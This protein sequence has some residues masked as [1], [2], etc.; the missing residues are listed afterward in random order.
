MFFLVECGAFYRIELPYMVAQAVKN[1]PAMQET[2][3]M[4]IQSLGWE[5]PLERKW[6]PTPVFLPGESHG[7]RSLV[8]NSSWGCTESDTTKRLNSN[9]N[10][11]TLSSHLISSHQCSFPAALFHSG[12]QAALVI[13]SPWPPLDVTCLQAS[14]AFF[15]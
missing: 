8:D 5:D 4:Q 6:Q 9:N 7:Q 1:L 12:H 15:L 3:E 13:K 2:Q 14:P 10:I 11:N